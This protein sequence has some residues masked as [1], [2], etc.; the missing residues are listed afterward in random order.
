MRKQKYI[1]RL[2]YESSAVRGWWVRIPRLNKSKLFSDNIYGGKDA[3]ELAARMWRDKL[4]NDAP[5][6]KSATSDTGF[7]GININFRQGKSQVLAY[8]SIDLARN[9]ERL[10]ATISLNK[11]GLRPA[12]WDAA[13]R[14]GAFL[15]KHEKRTTQEIASEVYAKTHG[16][17]ETILKKHT[18]KFDKNARP[19]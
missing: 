7:E 19:T 17:I 18:P 1:T 16:R 10:Q 4:V 14:I 3:A 11:R 6:D 2:E 13:R 12:L 15:S 8:L 5:A 9:Q